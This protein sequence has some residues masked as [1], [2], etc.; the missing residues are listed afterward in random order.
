MGFT[1][2]VSGAAM[3]KAGLNANAD[4]KVSGAALKQWS[5]DAEGYIESQTRRNWVDKYSTLPTG[6][7]G[8]LSDICSSLIAK[9]I[10]SYD[11]SG[12]TSR[13]EATTMLDVQDDIVKIGLSVLKDFKSAELK[14]P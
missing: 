5:D 3:L 9:Q 8:V 11:M 6:I 2:T 7:K 4:I 13:Q 14:D 1:L 12:Y 10:I